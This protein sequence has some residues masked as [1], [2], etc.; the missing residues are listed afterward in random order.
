MLGCIAKTKNYH[1]F[2]VYYH[3]LILAS[4]TFAAKHDSEL[5]DQLE[6][7]AGRLAVAGIIRAPPIGK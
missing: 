4:Q 5:A 1:I 6:M 3:I 2:Q 7:T